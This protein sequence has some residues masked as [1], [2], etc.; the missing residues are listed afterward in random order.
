NSIH[1]SCFILASVTPLTYEFQNKKMEVKQM[2]VFS[3]LMI[4]LVVGARSSEDMIKQ[5]VFIPIVGRCVPHSVPK[6]NRPFWDRM[7]R[8]C[9]DRELVCVHGICDCHGRIHT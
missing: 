4:V 2:T 6:Q 9:S 8:R 5:C 7:I 1:I 3:I